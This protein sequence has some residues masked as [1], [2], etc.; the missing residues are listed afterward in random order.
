MPRGSEYISQSAYP[1]AK[2]PNVSRS[3]T[4]PP[5]AMTVSS[6]STIIPDAGTITHKNASTASAALRL[7]IPAS[8]FARRER[9]ER[10]ETTN[11][12]AKPETSRQ[13]RRDG[14]TRPTEEDRAARS[15]VVEQRKSDSPVTDTN[16]PRPP[17]VC[18]ARPESVVALYGHSRGTI[19]D[20]PS[21]GD[22]SRSARTSLRLG[23]L[24][25]ASRQTDTSKERHRVLS[26]NLQI[27]S[28]TT[29]QLVA[30]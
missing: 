28:S 16:P 4:V 26:V 13:T 11:T 10:F 1:P 17:R 7:S 29:G 2:N 24:P 8:I 21:P 27:R 19:P 22:V 9:P 3:I 6:F 23:F 5:S 15:T 14:R 12:R 25:T 20:S 30:R 18:A